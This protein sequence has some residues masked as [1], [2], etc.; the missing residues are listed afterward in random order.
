MKKNSLPS[1]YERFQ[2]ASLIL[3]DELAIDR[4]ILSNERTLLAYLR[5]SLS[6]I[7]VGVTFLHLVSEGFLFYLGIIIIPLGVIV[8][9]FGVFRHQT[10]SREIHKVRRK[11]DASPQPPSG[12][13]T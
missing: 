11:L 6:L 10:M 4:T 7:L 8:G 5:S 13:N 9:V 2:N 3:R 1:P 12:N